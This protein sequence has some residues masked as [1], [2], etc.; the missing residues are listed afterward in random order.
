[1]NV[2]QANVCQRPA[3]TALSHIFRRRALWIDVLYESGA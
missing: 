2:G 3:V 1:M